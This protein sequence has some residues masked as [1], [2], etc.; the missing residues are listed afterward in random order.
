[1]LR[2]GDCMSDEMMDADSGLELDDVIGFEEDPPRD[3]MEP[4][5]YNPD[6]LLL[7]I[8]GYEGPIDVL[9]VM[10]RDQKVDLAKIS[11]LQLTRQY[12]VFM[13]RAKAMNLDLAAEYLV[14][15]AWL[16]YL[17][18]RLLLPREE[19]K[20]NE[21]SADQM[22]EA[23]QFQLR[24]LEAMKNAANALFRR[25]YLGNG[26]YT[27]GMPEGLG[28][29]TDITWDITL[30]DLLK[31]YGDIRRRQEFST[32][33]LPVFSIMTM[34]EAL[35]RVGTMLGKLPRKGP[36]SAWVT[37]NSL[38]PEKIKDPLY[39]RSSMASTFT[40]GLEL[41][42][43]G[44]VEIKQDGLFRPIYMRAT[45]V[46]RDRVGGPD[47]EPS[48]DIEQDNNPDAADGFDGESETSYAEAGV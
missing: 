48:D 31:A 20:G 11:I 18:S 12:L 1:M 13:D 7:N 34:E 39:G 26:I 15:A 24:R 30:F 32:F 9:L 22:A 45:F 14:M 35:D 36:Y 29:K 46:D 17:K 44:K 6:E 21:P 19:S 47:S 33:E 43:Q 25:P 4:G 28:V 10:A 38:M 37:M 3:G 40:A 23:L 42:K 5:E 41:V 2:M 27:R 16:A 8:D